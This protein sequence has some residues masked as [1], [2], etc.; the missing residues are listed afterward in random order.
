MSPEHK[1]RL[2]ENYGGSNKKF[3]GVFVVE[4][5]WKE[6]SKDIYDI[7][8]TFEG[9]VYDLSPATKTPKEKPKPKA[10]PV[11]VEIE[12]PI[13]ADSDDIDDT[14]I[15]FPEELE[16]EEP[17]EEPT[18]PEEIEGVEVIVKEAPA[19]DEVKEAPKPEKPKKAKKKSGKSGK[20]KR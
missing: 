9:T 7:A 20:R 6:C 14:V 19:V 12:E 4:R 17:K 16:E 11:T 18:G 5:E 15:L 3:I 10:P 1:I 13:E 2:S 8:L